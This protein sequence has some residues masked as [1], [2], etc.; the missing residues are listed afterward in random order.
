MDTV[1]KGTKIEASK[2]GFAPPNVL[3]NGAKLVWVN[4]DKS[5]FNVETPWMS[6]PW[7]LSSFT[8]GEYPKHSVTLSFRGMD[9]DTTGKTDKEIKQNSSLK[10]FHDN[11]CDVDNVLIDGAV[12]NSK[13]WFKKASISRDVAE[14]LFN[15]II[16][17]SKD[18]ETGEPDGKFAP[19][20]RIKV[21]Q[22]DGIWECKVYDKDGK[23]QYMINDPESGD[24]MEDLMTK[25]SKIKCILN[26]VGLWVASGNYMCQWKLTMA[27]VDVAASSLN[28]GFGSDSDD[29][30]ADAEPKKE[31]SPAPVAVMDS[32]DSDAP[33]DHAPEEPDEVV[34]AP[35]KVKK[36]RKKKGPE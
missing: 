23:K 2:L 10:E 14:N 35:T 4:Y 26:C 13:E 16:K 24:R 33:G 3:S 21:P 18:K 28:V 36:P 20:M 8:E 9:D 6:L 27:R 34:M 32:D 30:E 15:P 31:S 7:P 19:T 25:N 17:V 12:S 22:R 11:L 29:D 5:R 1:Q